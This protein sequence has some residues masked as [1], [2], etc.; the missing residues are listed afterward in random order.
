M[1][2]A[3]I[4]YYSKLEK[5]LDINLQKKQESFKALRQIIRSLHESVT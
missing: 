5:G 4:H 3:D 2:L 1:S